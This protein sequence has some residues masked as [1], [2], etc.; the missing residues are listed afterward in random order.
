M[1]RWKW[2]PALPK[3]DMLSSVEAKGTGTKR[4]RLTGTDQN[5][6]QLGEE[7]ATLRAGNYLVDSPVIHGH[8]DRAI[9]WEHL[10]LQTKAS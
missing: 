3:L 7:Y 4:S 6:N 8:R 9:R 10:L 5:E 2:Y 1:R